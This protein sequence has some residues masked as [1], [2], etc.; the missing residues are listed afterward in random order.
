[1]KTHLYIKISILT[2][3]ANITLHGQITWNDCQTA[4]RANYPT[5]KQLDL[6]QYTRQLNV[7]NVN[8]GWIPQVNVS[9]QAQYQNNVTAFP[10]EMEELYRQIGVNMKGL[11]K[12]Q[13]KIAAEVGQLIWDGGN[14]KTRK[15]VI[16]KQAEIN[17]QNAEIELFMIKEQVNNLFFGILVLEQQLQ[18]NRLLNNLLYSNLLTIQ[19]QKQNGIA[20]DADVQ[21]VEAEVLS[22][23]QQQIHITNANNAYRLMLQI[24]TGLPVNEDVTLV[25]PKPIQQIHFNNL[26]PELQLMDAQLQHYQALKDNLK[27]NTRPK[28]NAFAQAFY[29][30]PGLNLFDDMINKQLSWNYLTGIKLQ[31]NFA[32]LYTYKNDVKKL[33][34]AQQN[35]N[36]KKDAFLFH[37]NLQ[38]THLQA[39]INE[40]NQLL[41]N[42]DKIARLRT[43]IR[44]ASEAK[45]SNGTITV[46]ELLKDITA[47]DNA[48]KNKAIHELEWLKKQY[49]LLITTNNTT[50]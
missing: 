3:A 48:L 16:I 2:L 13:Y 41:D 20:T 43:K 21:N 5:I 46:S 38:Q 8:K 14:S 47:E 9:A 42:D 12:E 22:A 34:I 26:R 4:A 37:A 7:G 28:I 15:N 29:G 35:I 50:P 18:Q 39:N 24:I 36:L 10:K 30:Y 31:W 45:L 27:T 1:M 23:K 11:G 49:D 25:K 32:S 17:T 33:N 40:F 44:I 19:A 6:L